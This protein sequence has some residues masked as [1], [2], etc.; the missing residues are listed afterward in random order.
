MPELPE[1]ESIRSGLSL[2]I[3][4]DSKL[5]R[6]AFYRN[7]LRFVI[8]KKQLNQLLGQ[9]LISIK[10]RAKYL[11]FVFTEGTMISHLGMTGNWR[12]TQCKTQKHDHVC[13]T[14]SNQL[15]LIYNDPRRFGYLDYIINSKDI[16]QH[17]YFAHLGPEPFDKEFTKEYLKSKAKRSNRKIKVFLMDQAVVVG[18]GNIYASEILFKAG[19]K[20]QRKVNKVKDSDWIAIIEASQSI[21]QKAIDLGGSTIRDYKKS[22]G[23]SGNFQDQHLVYD[24]KDQA[25][26]KCKS[27]ILTA[28]IAG[29]STYWCPKCQS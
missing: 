7:D 16:N 25:C 23:S 26:I 9:N 21:L 12:T 11:L 24:H 6:I 14:F 29:R 19:I 27:K 15:Q 8:P 28:T 1:V 3:P 10:R 5:N 4:N 18:I 13:F 2:E 22:D 17:P 20:P